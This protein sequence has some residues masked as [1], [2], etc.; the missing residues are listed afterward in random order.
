[1]YDSMGDYKTAL[2]HY[3]KSLDIRQQALP[4]NHP[5]LAFSHNNIARLCDWL[6]D[7]KIALCH[8]HK[9]T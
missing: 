8:Y 1:M 3:H 5:H 2:S 7:N 4:E 9:A 6:G